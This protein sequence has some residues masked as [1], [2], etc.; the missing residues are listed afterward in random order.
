MSKRSSQNGSLPFDPKA[1]GAI[2]V[3]I[4]ILI[5]L[6][7]ACLSSQGSPLPPELVGMAEEIVTA[8]A[9]E[10]EYSQPQYDPEATPTRRPRRTPTPEFAD[11]TEEVTEESTEETTVDADFDYYVLALSWQ[12]AF[13]ESKPDKEECQTQTERR[14]DATNFVLHGLWPN[15]QGD[16][17]HTFGYC[18]VSRSIIRQDQNSDWCDMPDI[19]LSEKVF[20]DLS[21]YMPGSGSCLQNHEWYK[22]GTCSGMSADAYYKL[23][24]A[25]VK[26]F[27]DSD[28]NQYVAQQVGRQVSRR[29]LLA[30]FTDEFGADADNYLSLR[31]TKVDGDSLLTEIQIALRADLTRA[32]DISNLFPD[33]DVPTQGNCP[34]QFQIDRAGLNNH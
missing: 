16:D 9:S 21:K 12:P 18:N 10:D 5:L 17:E 31:C 8:S 15:L 33:E 19:D 23:A 26:R 30:R 4:A 7:N 29:D 20:Q 13:C 25:L 1:G 28:F 14:Y 27:N 11:V 3:I 22:H 24:N 34:Q 32:D 2:L 6:V